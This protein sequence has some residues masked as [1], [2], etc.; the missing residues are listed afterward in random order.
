MNR[1]GRDVVRARWLRIFRR[2]DETPRP[3]NVLNLSES[4][5]VNFM[6]RREE[7]FKI[8]RACEKWREPQRFFQEGVF[9]NRLLSSVD[10]HF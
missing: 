1:S 10:G 8:Q 6:K 7:L 3:K 9:R 2:G 5:F 4:R